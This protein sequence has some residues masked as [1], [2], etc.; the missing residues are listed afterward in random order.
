[1]HTLQLTQNEYARA[2]LL[3]S[4]HRPVYAI[5][6]VV[7]HDVDEAKRA[8]LAEKLTRDLRR[9]TGNMSDSQDLE[10]S[11]VKMKM[12][13]ESAGEKSEKLGLEGKVAVGRSE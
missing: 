6:S 8:T 10:K 12:L 5:F 9:T 2:E 7:V 13:S 4:D 1:L 11:F 3:T